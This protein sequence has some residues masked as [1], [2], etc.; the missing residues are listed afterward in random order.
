METD[1][2]M[3]AAA[4]PLFH[5]PPLAKADDTRAPRG[6][7]DAPAASR[8]LVARVRAALGTGEQVS[9]TA[10]FLLP[11]GPGARDRTGGAPPR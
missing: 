8:R 4:M 9:Q 6:G 3:S 2:S 11:R 10:F 5:S 7:T 1:I